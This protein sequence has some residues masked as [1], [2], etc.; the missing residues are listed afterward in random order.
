MKKKIILDISLIFILL[1]VSLSALL[2]VKSGREAGAY[3]KVTVG[4]NAPVTYLLDTDGEF[5]LN[6]GTNILIIE[7]GEAYMKSADCPDKTCVK[8]GRISHTGERI[9]CLPNKIIVEVLGAP[10]EIIGG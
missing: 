8:S 6:G 5:S 4:N 10:D 7:G 3:V 9:V 2:I 1:I